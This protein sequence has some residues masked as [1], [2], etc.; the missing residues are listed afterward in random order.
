[1]ITIYDDNYG[2]NR[3]I[4]SGIMGARGAGDWVASENIQFLL[5]F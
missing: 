4:V 3:S 2:A 5:S 1:M